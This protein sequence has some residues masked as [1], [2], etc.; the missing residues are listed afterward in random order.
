MKIM[1]KQFPVH[2]ALPE[3]GYAWFDFSLHT[4]SLYLKFFKILKYPHVI[5]IMLKI[6]MMPVLTPNSATPTQAHKH[7]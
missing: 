4:L 6:S 7:R 3:I 2:D 5:K 1:I